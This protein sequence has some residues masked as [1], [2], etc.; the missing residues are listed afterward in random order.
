TLSAHHRSH[1]DRGWLR[2]A[3]G[4]WWR[5]VQ[6]AAELSFRALPNRST[7]H[8]ERL[9]LSPGGDL[10]WVCAAGACL[11]CHDLQFGVCD[12]DAGLDLAA[13]S[14]VISLLLSPET[15]GKVLVSDLVVA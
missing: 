10:R 6:P 3:R 11:L 15:K 7:G 1:L 5:P 14:V 13:A 8:C 9:L 12:S 2:T 4:V